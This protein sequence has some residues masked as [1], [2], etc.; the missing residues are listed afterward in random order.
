MNKKTKT[1]RFPR[2]MNQDGSHAR[3]RAKTWGTDPRKDKTKRKELKDRLK[4]GNWEL[5]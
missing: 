3:C 5:D 4:E 1:K 2:K